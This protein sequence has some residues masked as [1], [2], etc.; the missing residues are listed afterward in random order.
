MKKIINNTYYKDITNQWIRNDTV[1]KKILIEYKIGDSFRYNKKRYIID[2][3][4]V[5]YDYKIGGKTFAKWLLSVSDKRIELLPRFN[6][7]DGIKSAD[8]KI[9]GEYFDYKHTTGKSPQLILH[10]LRG[11]EAQAS[12][13]IINITNNE[14][15]SNQFEIERQVNE[16][17]RKYKWVKIIGIKTFY[18][19][20][21]YQRK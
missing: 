14:L 12:N 2:G 15:A 3:I 7:P 21:I 18:S 13:F 4:N 6:K 8:Y 11:K 5:L 17:F 9:N 1:S 19:F 20:K 16:T 10:N